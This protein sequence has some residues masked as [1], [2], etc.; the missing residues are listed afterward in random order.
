M[1]QAA[2]LLAAAITVAANPLNLRECDG[3]NCTQ[4]GALAVRGLREATR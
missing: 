4:P 1:L 3:I 2:I